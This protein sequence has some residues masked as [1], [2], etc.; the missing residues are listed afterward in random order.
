M[1]HNHALSWFRIWNQLQVAI[2]SVYKCPQRL[3]HCRRHVDSDEGKNDAAAVDADDKHKVDDAPQ[4]L[5][6]GI[7]HA[8][9]RHLH[10]EMTI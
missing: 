10:C 3:L 8:G 6:S 1:R 9:N 5:I 2:K 7:L 4:D